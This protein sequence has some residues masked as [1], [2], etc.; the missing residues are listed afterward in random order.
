VLPK[1]AFYWRQD[2][3]PAILADFLG[4]LPRMK[5]VSWMNLRRYYIFETESG[6]L[7]LGL[8]GM[9]TDNVVSILHPC[10]F[11]IILRQAHHLEVGCHYNHV[12]SCF[13]LGLMKGEA[14][15]LNSKGEWQRQEIEIR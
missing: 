5:Q 13:V 14:G 2:L 7:G 6:Y 8:V 10:K 3:P 15:Q 11:P 12:G 4:W 1:S 9:R